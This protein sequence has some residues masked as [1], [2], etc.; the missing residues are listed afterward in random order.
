M[1]ANVE[2]LSLFDPEGYSEGGGF[3]NDVDVTVMEARVVTGADSPFKENVDSHSRTYVAITF[4][5]DGEDTEPRDEY[6]GIGPLEKFSP[7]KD[8]TRVIAEGEARPNKNAKFSLFIKSLIAAGFNRAELP[9]DASVSFLVGQRFHVIQTG[10]PEM[11]GGKEL[12]DK[13]GNEI[14]GKVVLVQAILEAKAVKGT[15][16][17]PAAAAKSKPAAAAAAADD[18]G[19]EGGDDMNVTVQGPVLEAVIA[20]EKLG[21]RYLPTLIMKAFQKD[22]ATMKAALKLVQ[23][24]TW[25]GS[26]DRPWSY[27]AGAAELTPLE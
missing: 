1:K 2:G 6:Y 13:D 22:Q 5:P 26:K 18:A 25:L 21:K 14:K 20:K 23:D 11:K 10:M 12:K 7:S 8:K 24:D 17:K 27:D 16:A 3:L 4:Q 9:K 15:K 19:D